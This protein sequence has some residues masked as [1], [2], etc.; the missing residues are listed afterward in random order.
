MLRDRDTVPGEHIQPPGSTFPW[1][2]TWSFQLEWS[3]FNY[4]KNYNEV[5][6]WSIQFTNFLIYLYW[7]LV[8]KH[9]RIFQH[10]EI[11]YKWLQL[12]LKPE[13]LAVEQLPIIFPV[14]TVLV[15]YYLMLKQ[16]PMVLSGVDP[17]Q[18]RNQKTRGRSNK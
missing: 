2:Y 14:Q 7:A 8:K 17:K 11:H 5:L 1:V 16:K 6:Q 12:T 10:C 15:L 13:N 3:F 4:L 18:I 9:S